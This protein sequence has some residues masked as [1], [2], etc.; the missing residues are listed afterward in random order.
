MSVQPAA[1]VICHLLISLSYICKN[2]HGGNDRFLCGKAGQR[3][4]HRLP[5]AKAQRCKQRCDEHHRLQPVS[6]LPLSSTRPKPPF[7]KPNPAKEP[8][9]Y[10]GKEQDCTSLDDEAFQSFPYMKQYG[11]S[12][13]EH[14]TDGSSITNGA[15]F[16]GE[17]FGFL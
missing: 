17:R 5:L 1:T 10:A 3:S 14:G 13:T 8:H 7:S 4:C 12:L 9:N 11:L 2:A 16:A 6:C 15:G